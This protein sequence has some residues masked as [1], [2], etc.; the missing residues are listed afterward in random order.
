MI[1]SIHSWIAL[2]K[3]QIKRTKGPCHIRNKMFT[4]AKKVCIKAAKI[5]MPKHY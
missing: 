4:Q 1:L 3:I 5:Q 2:P